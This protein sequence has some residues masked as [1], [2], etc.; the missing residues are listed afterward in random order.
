MTRTGTVRCPRPSAL[1]ATL[2]VLC[3]LS[4]SDGFVC[5]GGGQGGG[6]GEGD[7][8]ALLHAKNIL[9][10]CCG[11][12]SDRA[13]AVDVSLGA[14]DHVRVD[15]PCLG[16]CSLNSDTTI[17][18]LRLQDR[19]LEFSAPARSCTVRAAVRR[20]A[21]GVLPGTSGCHPGGSQ[22]HK[23]HCHDPP[24]CHQEIASRRAWGRV[25]PACSRRARRRTA[26]VTRRRAAQTSAS[27][28][29]LSR[30][31]ISLEHG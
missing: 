21:S 13:A 7:R 5:V 24:C 28:L 9:V 6:R 15:G 10:C 17:S 8:R 20:R 23:L 4:L 18:R 29:G 30:V 12:S 27:P 11:A 2:N 22:S 26:P 14:L 25:S 19:P 3:T 16:L 31:I 1:H